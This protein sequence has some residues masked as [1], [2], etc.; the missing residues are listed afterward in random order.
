VQR[1]LCRLRQARA[2][3]ADRAGHAREGLAARRRSLA[4]LSVRAR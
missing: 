1:A 2:A 3:A 4:H